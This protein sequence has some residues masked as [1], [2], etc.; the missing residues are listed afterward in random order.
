[1][2]AVVES[3]ADNGWFCVNCGTVLERDDVR[4]RDVIELYH[5][6]PDEPSIE[7]GPVRACHWLQRSEGEGILEDRYWLLVD[8]ETGEVYD[9]R[10]DRRR[11]FRIFDEV[12]AKWAL[13]R[14]FEADLREQHARD[15]LARVTR[16]ASVA[17]RRHENEAKRLRFLF[18][19]QLEAYTRRELEGAKVRSIP[20]PWGTLKLT[21]TQA[22]W[23]VVDVGRAVAWL[24]KRLPDAVKVEKSVL[25]SRL[26][27]PDQLAGLVSPEG[28]LE[29]EPGGDSFTIANDAKGGRS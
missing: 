12:T 27:K 7:C 20:T 21:R 1:M 18:A 17:I 29:I 8:G 14:I 23:R 28:G 3:Y 19:G 15:W 13:R 5:P 6:D 24:E 9:A 16:Q 10:T 25:V 26:P 22:K 2:S 11:P 4:I